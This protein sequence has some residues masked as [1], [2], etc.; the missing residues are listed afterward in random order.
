ME[1]IDH[2]GHVFTI[3]SY[4]SFPTGYMFSENPYIFWINDIGKLSVKNYYL[5]SIKIILDSNKWAFDE[6]THLS[7]KLESSAFGLIGSKTIN[8][9]L[10]KNSNIFEYIDLD[11]SVIKQELNEDDVILVSNLTNDDGDEYAMCTFYVVTYNESQDVLLTNILIDIYDNGYTVPIHEYCP[12]TVGAEF[13][14]ENEA[15]IIN[16]KNMGID[17]PKDI[18]RAVYSS[19]F[20][21]DVADES[22]YNYKLKELLLNYMDIKGECGN[23]KSVLSSLKW[24]G[25]GNKLKIT[26]LLETDNQFINQYIVDSFDINNDVLE[27][28]RLFRNTTYIKLFV[29]GTIESDDSTSFDFDSDFWG[30][31]KPIIKDVVNANSYSIYDEN[32]IKF[33]KPYYD[34]LFD[35]LGLKLS[36]LEYYYKKYFLPIHLFI[37]NSSIQF[38]CHMN[39][40]KIMVGENKT[41]YSEIPQ[42]TY[43][44][45]NNVTV[46]FPDKDYLL[47]KTET[48]LIDQN[49]NEFYKYILDDYSSSRD[50]YYWVYENVMSLPIKFSQYDSDGNELGEQYYDCHLILDKLDKATYNYLYSFPFYLDYDEFL[51]LNVVDEENVNITNNIVISHQLYEVDIETQSLISTNKWSPYMSYIDTKKYILENYID[52]LHFNVK[53]P[54]LNIKLKSIKYIKQLRAGNFD[55]VKYCDCEILDDTHNVVYESDFKFVQKR[56]DKGS[57]YKNF[58]I[59]PKVFG[60]QYDIKFWLNSELNIYLCVNGKWFTYNFN[61][62][63]PEFQLEIGKLFYKYYLDASD[64]YINQHGTATMFN[65]LQKL[66]D[67]D[68]KFNMFM[69]QPN[70][71]KV[72]NID[73]FDNLL[74]YYNHDKYNITYNDKTSNINIQSFINNI[75]GPSLGDNDKN[76]LNNELFYILT[77]NDQKFYIHKDVIT[78]YLIRNGNNNILLN[79]NTDLSEYN[80]N[81]D[82][83]IY[84]SNSDSKIGYYGIYSEGHY[85]GYDDTSDNIELYRNSSGSLNL[86]ENGAN[87]LILNEAGETLKF[88]TIKNNKVDPNILDLT[89]RDSYVIIYEDEQSDSVDKYCLPIWFE[90]DEDN[91]IHFYILDINNNKVY[92]NIEKTMYKNMDLIYDMYK[93]FP[94]IVNNERYINRV[95]L[96]DIYKNGKQFKYNKDLSKQD[97]IDIYNIFF[98]QDSHNDNYCLPKITLPG[99]EDMYDFYLMHDENIWYSLF[100]SKLTN[101]IY[102]QKQLDINDDGKE[103]RFKHLLDK[104][105]VIDEENT[106]IKNYYNINRAI[107]DRLKLETGLT[108]SDFYIVF[109]E[110]AGS[111]GDNENIEDMLSKALIN[112][113]FNKNIGSNIGAS[114]DDDDDII[115]WNDDNDFAISQNWCRIHPDD[116]YCPLCGSN[117]YVQLVFDRDE[118]GIEKHDLPYSVQCH[119]PKHYDEFTEHYYTISSGNSLIREAIFIWN[120][121]SIKYKLIYSITKDPYFHEGTTDKPAQYTYSM[122]NKLYYITEHIDENGD[123]V[124]KDANGNLIDVHTEYKN[125]DLSNLI[126]DKDRDTYI[127]SI[128]NEED[129]LT[130]EYDF[131]YGL[132]SNYINHYIYLDTID[133]YPVIN[134]STNM[135]SG[136]I[137]NDFYILYDGK[138]LYHDAWYLM[139]RSSATS[140]NDIIEITKLESDEKLN[141]VIN[142]NYSFN[143]SIYKYYMSDIVNKYEKTYID[144]DGNKPNIDIY[145]DSSGKFF[146]LYYNGTVWT[147]RIIYREYIDKQEIESNKN[148]YDISTNIYY[149]LDDENVILNTEETWNI[150]DENNRPSK[151]DNL[152][153]IYDEK[154]SLWKV[155]IY[156]GEDANINNSIDIKWYYKINTDIYKYTGEVTNNGNDILSSEYV[157]ITLDKPI[158]VYLNVINETIGHPAYYDITDDYKF[159]YVKSDDKFLI[160]RMQY[161][162]MKGNNKFN[163]NDIIV[164]SI[165][166]KMD[167]NNF[168]Y[169]TEH[170]LGY[171]TKWVFEP[172]S[173]KMTNTAFVESNTEM[174]IMSIGDS[175]IKYERGYYNLKCN[176][177]LDGTTENIYTKTARIL[178]E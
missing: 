120:D 93:E 123:K 25:W 49:Y 35:E 69:W 75:E 128:Y 64:S 109:N 76:I 143:T 7:I 12:I 5:K 131:I 106:G 2:T 38:Q 83:I 39:D 89:S 98:N 145:L 163:N 80:K 73:F 116:I 161:V 155:L 66:S 58:V 16:G 26:K 121:N 170:K 125:H 55:Y 87:F 140:I 136:N 61:C 92:L 174:A 167:K 107:L 127:A 144:F 150:L 139:I 21:N 36:A 142:P 100:I 34:F 165:S 166:D 176:Y 23:Y 164:A 171:S 37:H 47:L 52:T 132:D 82:Y 29:Q 95:H 4:K 27:S 177:S 60:K 168:E 42:V 154:T 101:N 148:L 112:K 56:D 79:V 152:Y 59:V 90:L 40:V 126:Y 17:L 110:I 117:E 99:E 72:N 172:M 102:S 124:Y 48:H 122:N 85:I 24:F 10:L 111:E 63:V 178:V 162:S 65:Q 149:S 169:K 141:W 158:K 13:A 32:D 33:Y 157:K 19:S 114:E 14:D 91:V 147:K 6:N 71:V 70:L 160:N 22:L 50:D 103:F 78:T 138:K 105:Y 74:N 3:A 173:L 113:V 57:Y 20:Y 28:Y 46:T 15:L 115:G 1:F 18:L 104:A 97:M 11:K 51:T 137:S 159:V 9:L 175:N 133:V 119:N 81:L 31:A 153:Y 44:V 156:L 41:I 45:N 129:G 68:I 43:D 134:G 151:P 88:S 96:Y 8:D 77:L 84:Y 94:N 54:T 53:K 62:K 86:L 67:T 108:D 118:N 135:D 130:H 146:S 30:E